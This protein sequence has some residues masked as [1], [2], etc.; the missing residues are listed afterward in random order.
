MKS[1]E[2]R[3]RVSERERLYIESSSSY[4]FIGDLEKA[5][6]VNELSVQFYPRD[7]GPHDTLG[8]IYTRLG[9]HEKALEQYRGGHCG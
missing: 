3:E 6:R 1:H 5:L 9:L 8:D 4:F 2:L 7:S